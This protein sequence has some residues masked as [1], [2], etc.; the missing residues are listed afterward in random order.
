LNQENIIFNIIE[1]GVLIMKKQSLLHNQEG[2]TL[3][4]IIAVLIILGILAAVAVPRYIDLEQSSKKR[5]LEAAVAELNGRESLVWADTKISG[6]GTSWTVMT[7]K[8]YTDPDSHLY[9]GADY[10]WESNPATSGVAD[11]TFK[12]KTATV[13]RIAESDTKPGSW[14]ITA[15]PQ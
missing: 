4:E 14:K 7:E 3:V 2:F 8:T 9:L 5:G 10:K 13:S 6:T 15:W 12:G 1:R 11:L